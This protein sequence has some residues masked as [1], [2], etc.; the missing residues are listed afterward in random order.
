MLPS[1]YPPLPSYATGFDMLLSYAAVE[2]PDHERAR[3]IVRTLRCDSLRRGAKLSAS[4]SLYCLCSLDAGPHFARRV[5]SSS[6]LQARRRSSGLRCPKGR[7]VTYSR[8][9]LQQDECYVSQS[10]AE[11]S[12]QKLLLSAR[13]AERRAAERLP[14]PSE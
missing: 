14:S 8:R 12:T 6:R 4:K 3:R 9:R 13:S 11:T 7:P 5:N 10:R 1:R 2:E